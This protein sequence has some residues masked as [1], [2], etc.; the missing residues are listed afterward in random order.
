MDVFR[1]ANTKCPS[2]TP[3]CQPLFTVHRIHLA[4]TLSLSTATQIHTLVVFPTRHVYAM[5]TLI[6]FILNLKHA[7][8]FPARDHVLLSRA[9]AFAEWVGGFVPAVRDTRDT[10]LVLVICE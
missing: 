5:I 8:Q 1:I 4:D 3:H 2:Q 10:G 6:A 7:F 9:W